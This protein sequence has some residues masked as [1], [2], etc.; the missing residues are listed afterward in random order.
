MNTQMKRAGRLIAICL[1]A[2]LSICSTRSYAAYNLIS[3]GSSYET[4]WASPGT[5]P[6]WMNNAVFS[7]SY[8]SVY[9][10][11]WDETGGNGLWAEVHDYAAHTF[12][13]HL[14]QVVVGAGG[15]VVHPD[16]VLGG[17][18]THN[19]MA[20]VYTGT[21]ILGASNVYIEVYTITNVGNAS[22][23]YNSCTGGGNTNQ[24]GNSGLVGNAH[25]DIASEAYGASYIR[26][27]RF[28]V[29]WEDGIAACI[30]GGNAGARA[31]AGSLSGLAGCTATFAFAPGCLNNVAGPSAGAGFDV[32]VTV[33]P[34]YNAGGYIAYFAYRDFYG[35]NYNIYQGDWHLGGT[36]NPGTISVT[37]TTN[38]VEWPRIDMYDS[39]TVGGGA[40]FEIAYRYYDNGVPEWNISKVDNNST[41]EITANYTPTGAHD[42]ENLKPVV[43]A[44]TEDL[45][46]GLEL[47]SL[48]YANPTLNYILEEN[49]DNA[50]GAVYQT[51]IY[52]DF[53]IV[54]NYGNSNGTYIDDPVA[55]SSNYVYDGGYS[56]VRP[57]ELYTCWYNTS[58]AGN[59]YC[60]TR[61]T[62]PPVFKPGNNTGNTVLKPVQQVQQGG[63][64]V[65]VYPIPAEDVVYIKRNG[66]QA[67]HYNIT[68]LT[69]RVVMEGQISEE[70]QAVNIAGMDRGMYLVNVSYSDSDD[71]DGI[72]IAK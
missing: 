38:P 2:S 49:I 69:G 62:A 61:S 60:K 43:A 24:I 7:N 37:S 66:R 39:P 26:A 40:P 28:V 5:A 20:V 6:D 16:V 56:Q 14:G 22:F 47:Y 8:G 68:D 54:N 17:D 33:G 31:A 9:A 42:Y 65:Q 58:G 72:R 4:S 34:D 48:A 29:A 51:T 10:E 21:S 59:I 18:G 15:T 11:V 1:L 32:D 44:G 13:I 70:V 45:G 57:D 53:R 25:I 27:D 23:G 41:L 3:P 46:T 63:T 67:S 19:Y 64:H 35:G 36:L 30:A 12:T 52:D 55:I 71:V 50:T